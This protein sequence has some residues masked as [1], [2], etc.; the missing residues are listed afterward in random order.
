MEVSVIKIKGQSRR[1]REVMRIR[2]S[3]LAFNKSIYGNET[4]LHNM[5]VILGF[6]F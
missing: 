5:A 4:A 2:K 1:I 3:T 6:K